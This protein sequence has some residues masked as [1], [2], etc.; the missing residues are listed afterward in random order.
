MERISTILYI[1]L[2]HVWERNVIGGIAFTFINLQ[3]TFTLHHKNT[4]KN[5]P[6]ILET[7]GLLLKYAFVVAEIISRGEIGKCC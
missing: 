3:L 6:I 1:V 5:D 7:L 4:H 2:V